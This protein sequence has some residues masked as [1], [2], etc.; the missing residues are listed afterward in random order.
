MAVTRELNLYS[1]NR[2]SFRC[3]PQQKLAFRHESCGT[4]LQRRAFGPCSTHQQATSTTSSTQDRSCELQCEQ[5]GDAEISQC[6]NSSRRT[7]HILSVSILPWRAPRLWKQKACQEAAHRDTQGNHSHNAA[8]GR[9]AEQRTA[10][11]LSLR[12][13]I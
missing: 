7:K 9:F 11:A 5:S 6:S 10:Y 1:C 12:H 13:K 4:N 2:Q 8:N 3:Q